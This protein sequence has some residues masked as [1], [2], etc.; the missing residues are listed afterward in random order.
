V[1]SRASAV[2]DMPNRP[3]STVDPGLLAQELR[4]IASRYKHILLFGH[5]MGG[6][7]AEV[8]AGKYFEAE[9]LG[10]RR[11]IAP[12]A[13]LVAFASP[14]GG[15]FPVSVPGIVDTAFLLRRSKMLEALRVFRSR[16]LDVELSESPNQDKHAFPI[17][18]LTATN[19]WWVGRYNGALGVPVR[20]VGDSGGT[21]S[22][23]VKPR[24]SSEKSVTF[25]LD[26]VERIVGMRQR[27]ADASRSN[28]VLDPDFRPGTIV[29]T[30]IDASDPAWDQAYGQALQAAQDAS[31]LVVLDSRY[32]AVDLT[33]Y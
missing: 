30:L 14:R 3:S 22:S 15:V 31:G 7:V 16:W 9:T 32:A 21:H 27:A 13:G 29:A 17:F 11:H 1:P 2:Y 20:Q 4:A 5:S 33:E 24:A 25:G 19:D 10:V 8:A 28:S 26:A 12:L 18:A 23:I 6:L